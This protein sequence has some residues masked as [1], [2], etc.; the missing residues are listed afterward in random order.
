MENTI[1]ITLNNPEIL[2]IIFCDSEDEKTELLNQL[3]GT[4]KE[5]QSNNS[6]AS[7]PKVVK[8]LPSEK[9]Y[10][11]I[12]NMSQDASDFENELASPK[13]D[14]E[15]KVE[16]L[17]PVPESEPLTLNEKIKIG[18]ISAGLVII[19]LCLLVLSLIICDYIEEYSSYT[20]PGI[21]IS[22]A[23]IKYVRIK[24]KKD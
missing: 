14:E 17:E 15:E 5:Y 2:G 22:L 18:F 8:R 16:I 12:S 21:L 4:I 9:V 1:E 24:A 13:E 23:V 3:T 10:S 11:M 7:N 6:R 19:S 20:I